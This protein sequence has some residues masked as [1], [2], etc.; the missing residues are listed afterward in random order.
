MT[1]L[2]QFLSSS[3]L[4]GSTVPGGTCGIFIATTG[5]PREMRCEKDLIEIISRNL[6]LLLECFIRYDPHHPNQLSRIA[7]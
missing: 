2:S 3:V 5:Y 7:L 6:S 1:A 4:Q